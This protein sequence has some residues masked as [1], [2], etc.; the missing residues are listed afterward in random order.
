MPPSPSPIVCLP[1]LP[2]LLAVM[3]Q[4]SQDPVPTTAPPSS[5]VHV[6]WWRQERLYN[7]V[8]SSSVMS[9]AAAPPPPPPSLPLL[10]HFNKESQPASPS[11]HIPLDLGDDRL[12]EERTYFMGCGE[13][14]SSVTLA[15][16]A[17]EM[18]PDTDTDTDSMAL[19]PETTSR[20]KDIQPPPYLVADLVRGIRSGDIC[21]VLTLHSL[22]G[23]TASD[24]AL[25]AT[26]QV[27]VVRDSRSAL[28]D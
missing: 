9:V 20:S 26:R 15:D 3:M 16:L 22:A 4:A 11:S 23:R 19:G 12:V 10:F 27:R 18:V 1:V 8:P 14:A 25:L 6:D 7:T 21:I 2:V 28:D 13:A 24:T 17:F 5:T